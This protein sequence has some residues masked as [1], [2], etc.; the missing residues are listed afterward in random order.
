[1]GRHYGRSKR[2][3][4]AVKAQ[5]FVQ[6]CHTSTIELLSLDGFVAGMTVEASLALWKFQSLDKVKTLFYMEVY[7]LSRF[8]SLEELFI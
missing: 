5:P 6:G 4:H 8:L 7:I 1:M 2:G 3:T